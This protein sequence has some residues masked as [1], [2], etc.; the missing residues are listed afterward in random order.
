[1]NAAIIYIEDMEEPGRVQVS[2]EIIGEPKHSYIIAARVIDQL[3]N[4]E[5]VTIVRD[6]DFT[7]DSPSSLLN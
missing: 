7:K 6:S 4:K 5:E 2:I 3:L 1:M